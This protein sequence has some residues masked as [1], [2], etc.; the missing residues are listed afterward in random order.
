M[1]G[2]TLSKVNQVLIY[3]SPRFSKF[4]LT[5]F[6]YY[7]LIGGWNINLE[8]FGKLYEWQNFVRYP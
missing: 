2:E 1:D 4:K 3:E 7:W 5:K 6:E 8:L